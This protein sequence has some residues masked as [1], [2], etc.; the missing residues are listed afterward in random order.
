MRNVL[1]RKGGGGGLACSAI[2]CDMVFAVDGIFESGAVVGVTDVGKGPE[3]SRSKFVTIFSRDGEVRCCR[4]DVFVETRLRGAS[5]C[6]S[7]ASRLL[8]DDEPWSW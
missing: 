4:C 5:C 2:G 7:M 6:S 1:G 3:E 8:D